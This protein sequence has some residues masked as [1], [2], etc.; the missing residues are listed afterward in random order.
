[1]LVKIQ[2]Q[3]GLTAKFIIRLNQRLT[4]RFPAQMDGYRMGSEIDNAAKTTVKGVY[5]VFNLSIPIHGI[6]A[7]IMWLFMIGTYA[8]CI[9]CAMQVNI[10]PQRNQWIKRQMCACLGLVFWDFLVVATVLESSHIYKFDDDDENDD[11]EQNTIC[12]YGC[13][14]NILTSCAVLI[15]V[16]VINLGFIFLPCLWSPVSEV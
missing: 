3:I 4:L 1:M 2:V 6:Y 13:M 7:L 9:L 15:V 12:Y 14:Q 10:N 16:L 8:L 11:D 5:E